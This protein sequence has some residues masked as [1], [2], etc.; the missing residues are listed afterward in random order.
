MYFVIFYL[1]IICNYWLD[2][3][4]SNILDKPL[5]EC[6]IEDGKLMYEKKW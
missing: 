3:S 6:R 4:G 5:T 2:F 1:N